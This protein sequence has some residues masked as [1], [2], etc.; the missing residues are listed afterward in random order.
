MLDRLAE[1]LKRHE[2]EYFL[3]AMSITQDRAAAED[4]VHDALV[5]VAA[6]N[7]A[8]TDLHAYLCRAVRNHALRLR[9]DPRE[10]RLDPDWLTAV[11][12]DDA[13]LA[14]SISQALRRLSDDQ[15]ETVV[16]HIYGGL[17]FQEIARVR[18]KSI[19]TVASWY[20]RGINTLKEF[21]DGP[22]RSRA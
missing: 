19:N 1:L 6:T 15:R 20:R 12:R 13:L 5:A 22:E 18:G 14:R 10:V 16:M 4:A 21:L 11:A 9:P 8:A 7:P 17:T 3:R 2:R